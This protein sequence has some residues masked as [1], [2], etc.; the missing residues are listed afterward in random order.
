M[1]PM[2]REDPAA[3]DVDVDIDER[4]RRALEPHPAV[5][6][7]LVRTALEG[8]APTAEGPA[9]RLGP[10]SRLA[11]AAAAVLILAAVLIPRF[12]PVPPGP[13]SPE[14]VGLPAPAAAA[15]LEISNEDGPVTVTTPAGSK[16]ILLPGDIS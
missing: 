4:L 7:R 14:V 13:A 10:I 8:T 2:D 3:V 16:M 1:D 9:R 12:R 6:D 15:V 5:V 11:F